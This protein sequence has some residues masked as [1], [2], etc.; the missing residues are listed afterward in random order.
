M[1]ECKDIDALM[2]DW[3]YGELD[4]SQEA[5]F[6]DHVATCARCRAELDSLKETRDAMR[7][8]PEEDPPPAL[9]AILLHE[10][11][12][13]APAPARGRAARAVAVD[14]RPGI[15]EW[16]A[17]L[18]RPLVQH[19][20]AAAVATLVLVAGV[21]GSLYLRGAHDVAEPLAI[22]DEEVAGERTAQS[23][24]AAAAAPAEDPALE[25]RGELASKRAEDRKSYAVQ[26]ADEGDSD[27]WS[28]TATAKEKSLDDGLM[29]KADTSFRNAN[30][31]PAVVEEAQKQP[32]RT[33]RMR[34]RKGT[35]PAGSGGAAAAAPLDFTAN[36]VSGA[37]PLVQLEESE[38]Y[39]KAPD[40]E[41]ANEDKLV[42]SQTSSGEVSGGLAGPRVDSN[43]DRRVA[44]KPRPA[45]KS[46]AKAKPTAKSERRLAKD[47]P[48]RSH[49]QVTSPVAPNAAPPPAEPAGSQSYRVYRDAKK[50]LEWA[51]T[52]QRKL[53]KALSTQRCRE[54]AKIANDILDRNPDFYYD[55]VAGT[56]SIKRCQWYV[57]NEQERRDR[58]RTKARAQKR[59]PAKAAEQAAP[60]DA[61]E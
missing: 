12:K 1:S 56:K 52:E 42:L 44:G 37:D 55:K 13:R 48:N 32:Q 46:A 53:S 51:K 60:A 39:A 38:G 41:R 21:A 10:A 43:A 19:P 16:L 50:E 4:E 35:A 36:A 58:K 27:Y 8:L 59:R 30:E 29:H 20:A 40:A 18:L 47:A 9:S 31:P 17:G 3:L 33:A 7:D 23:E 5:P 15:F 22:T 49:V 45:K 54:A 6:D 24:T 14:S 2:I 25:G 26:L 11:A 57:D 61:A 28:D 34:A